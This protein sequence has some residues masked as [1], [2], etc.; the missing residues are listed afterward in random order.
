MSANELEKC[1]LVN[2]KWNNLILATHA[3]ELSLWNFE[4]LQIVREQ[5]IVNTTIYPKN[6]NAG[7]LLTDQK[8]ASLKKAL[9]TKIKLL[10][11]PFESTSFE[12]ILA[13]CERLVQAA[14]KK[15]KSSEFRGKFKFFKLYLF[16]KDIRQC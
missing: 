11:E 13:E 1:Q 8:I 14:G 12:D 16:L 9:F 3:K 10:C 2:K 7:I 15:I 5:L 4:E 6:W